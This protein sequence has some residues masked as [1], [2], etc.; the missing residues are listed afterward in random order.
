MNLVVG[1][2][3]WNNDF[4]FNHKYN[5]HFQRPCIILS[6]KNDLIY[7]LPISHTDDKYAGKFILNTAKRKIR[8]IPLVTIYKTPEKA[9][10]TEIEYIDGDFLFEF[11]HSFYI[12]HT[13]SA[14]VDPDFLI[15]KEDI[16]QTLAK[17]SAPCQR[18]QKNTHN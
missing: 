9:S 11:L 10:Y 18:R 3:F 5:K 15:I 17:L 12:Y 14:F 6:I 13:N 4:V 8:Y 7:F 1:S 16:E 2:I